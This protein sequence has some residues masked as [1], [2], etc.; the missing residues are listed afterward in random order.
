MVF[1]LVDG[2]AALGLAAEETFEEEV[3]EFGVGVLQ[4]VCFVDL[5]FV[6]NDL[7]HDLKLVV[8][9]IERR[10]PRVEF[11]EENA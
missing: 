1:E 11:V 7:L 10:V 3:S 4:S 8:A 5:E 9:F 6:V 2:E